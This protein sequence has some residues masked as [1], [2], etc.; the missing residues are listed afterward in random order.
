MS[1]WEFWVEFD[2]RADQ[3]RRT[4][5]TE[6]GGRTVPVNA[7]EEAKARARKIHAAKK[8]KKAQEAAE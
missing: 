6:V 2:A 7:L 3:H 4:S 1:P 8:G 5:R